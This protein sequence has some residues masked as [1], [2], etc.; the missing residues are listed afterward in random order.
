MIHVQIASRLTLAGVDG[1][2]W[3]LVDDSDAPAPDD[4]PVPIPVNAVPLRLAPAEEAARGRVSL[5]L[6]KSLVMGAA[7]GVAIWMAQANFGAPTV[8][9]WQESPLPAKAGAVAPVAPTPT[10]T[11]TPQPAGGVDLPLAPVPAAP[12]ASAAVPT[13]TAANP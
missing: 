8:R 9:W 10:P 2:R 7:F 3:V 12:A 11:P 1:V 6:M 5:A 13:L 4:A